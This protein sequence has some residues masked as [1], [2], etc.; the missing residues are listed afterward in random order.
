MLFIACTYKSICNLIVLHASYRV[1]CMDARARTCVCVCVL[2]WYTNKTRVSN[3]LLKNICINL[4][5][6]IVWIVPLVYWLHARLAV[7]M[8]DIWMYKILYHTH[9]KAVSM[10][11]YRAVQLSNQAPDYKVYSPIE[12]E[13]I[14]D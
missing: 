2:D 5:F 9:T 11:I 6:N 3:V 13:P 14:Y 7:T 8:M 10:S 1:C 12:M 4:P